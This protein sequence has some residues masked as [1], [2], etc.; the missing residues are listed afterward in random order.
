MSVVFVFRV[1]KHSPGSLT[2]WGSQ[3]HVCRQEGV[4]RDTVGT[5]RH[6]AHQQLLLPEWS[7]C[8]Y[9]CAKTGMVQD[10]NKSSYVVHN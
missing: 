10:A 1:S 6:K 3:S 8:T 5:R 4:G 2:W 7:A 9:V